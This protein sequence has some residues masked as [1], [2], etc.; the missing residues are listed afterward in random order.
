MTA[1]RI[2]PVGFVAGVLAV[3]VF[4]QGM[5]GLLHL[6]GAVPNP[7]FQLRPVPPLG[8][9]QLVSACFWGGLWGILTA[10]IVAARP[11]WSPIWVGLAI[12]AVAC[13]LVGFVVV[14]GIRGQPL[15]GGMDPNRWWRSVAINGAFG[16]G[17]GVVLWGARRAGRI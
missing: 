9:P 10:A 11:G 3:L 15:M 1:V 8:V 17:V 5:V 16:L 4:H 14:A 13:V 7:P 6:L 2:I 12:G